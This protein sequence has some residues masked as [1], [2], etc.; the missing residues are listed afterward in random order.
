MIK[1]RYLNQVGPRLLE[2]SPRVT[3][4]RVSESQRAKLTQYLT[5][6]ELSKQTEKFDYSPRILSPAGLL[7]ISC[8][9][10]VAG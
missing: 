3:S 9:A 1:S 8:S 6:C 4:L 5:V 7:P 2:S 10:F